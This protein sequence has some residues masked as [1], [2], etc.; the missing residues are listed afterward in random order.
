MAMPQQQ[1]PRSTGESLAT[2]TTR[3]LC[4]AGHLDETFQ[5]YVMRNI[6]YEE[7]RA[8]GE[9]YGVDMGAVVSWCQSGLRRIN[10]RD[11]LLTILFALVILGY[12]LTI[13]TA[14]AAFSAAGASQSFSPFSSFQIILQLLQ[15]V[16]TLLLGI[17]ILPIA[18]NVE[19]WI[20][21]R[22]PK[23]LVGLITYP[24]LFAF[25]GI[26]AVPLAWLI[27]FVELLIRFYGEPTKRLR[28]DTFN[29]H[30]RPVQLD[31][32]LEAKLQESFTTGQRNVIAYSGFRP[33]AGAGYYKGGWSFVIDTSKGTQDTSSSL[34]A[35]DKRLSP[36]P[37][38][39]SSLYD[40]V[41]RDVWALGLKNVIEIEGKLYVNGQ[42]LPE[43]PS[44]FNM[45]AM[46]PVTSVEANQIEEYKE[47]PTEDI[48][49][50]QCLRFNFWRGEMIFTAFLRF[51]RRGKDLFAEI[52]YL[53]LPPMQ[54]DY[55]WADEKE[56]VAPLSKFWELYLRTFRAPIET[57]LGAPFRL[58]RGYT[59]SSQQR[60]LARIA[61][62]SP[63]F[64]YG[65]ATSLRQEASDDEY[66]LF[67]QKLDE[68]MYLKIIE[69]QILETIVAFLKE[70]QIDT[71]D[72]VQREQ[73][74]LNN[75]TFNG[76]NNFGNQNVHGGNNNFGN[77]SSSST[78]SSQN[79]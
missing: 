33:F 7:R 61:R 56:L 51:V 15:G 20:R 57:W 35:P 2:D 53:L 67:F 70:H 52:D 38:T 58:L 24:I 77:Q 79:A 30:V 72:L 45:N 27:I 12:L 8:L 50:Y 42:Y 48:R 74:I 36:Q 78:G 25:T 55:H 46:R 21:L 76:N 13:F 49:Y 64:D 54:R 39:L 75:N 68:Q 71:T 63:A 41:E 69:K 32:N 59:Y 60:R 6:I 29:P 66:H 10:T 17:I 40:A 62:N 16:G 65:A 3:Y 14:I 5:D 11:L 47:Q 19:K 31:Q 28:K 9:S 22:W 43:K 26:L 23:F 4:A 37:F 73:A 1:A 18:L 44:F 34:T